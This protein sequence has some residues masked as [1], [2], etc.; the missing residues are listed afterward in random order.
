MEGLMKNLNDD[1]GSTFDKFRSPQSVEIRPEGG[2]DQAFVMGETYNEREQNS[3]DMTEEWA[4]EY[5]NK[6]RFNL[7]QGEGSS[8]FVA[9]RTLQK[10]KPRREGPE[11]AALP[12]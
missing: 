11:N 7:Q 8:T 9:G 2:T 5:Y 3:L 4:P 10:A 1:G 12:R 6:E